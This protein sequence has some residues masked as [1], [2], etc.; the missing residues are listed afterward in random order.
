MAL[1]SKNELYGWGAGE[2]G[3]LGSGKVKYPF[4]PFILTS[5]LIILI[6][7]VTNK[8]KHENSP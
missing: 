5:I 2:F 1:T 7:I 6:C 8:M 4:E 3:E